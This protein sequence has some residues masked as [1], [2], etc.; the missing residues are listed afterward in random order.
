MT[1]NEV[2]QTGEDQDAEETNQ[3]LYRTTGADKTDFSRRDILRLGAAAAGAA[4]T[5]G[6][7]TQI[8][9]LDPV[10]EADAIAAS[11]AIAVAATGILV[12][13]AAENY[14]VFSRD[15]GSRPSPE[16]VE[17]A[18]ADQAH[19]DSY[20]NIRGQR[21]AAE[22]FHRQV[23]DIATGPKG[24]GLS[25]VLW[26][27]IRKAVY[28]SL[29]NGETVTEAITAA[30]DAARQY[31]SDRMERWIN[32]WNRYC[33]E[34]EYERYVLH[35]KALN[36]DTFTEIDVYAS[37]QYETY[38]YQG[39]FEAN[40]PSGYESGNI[41]NFADTRTKFEMTLPD[42]RTKTVEVAYLSI[43]DYVAGISENYAHRLY[44]PGATME[45]LPGKESTDW[46][47][48]FVDGHYAPLALGGND[49]TSRK[50]GGYTIS[51]S[52]V[53]SIASPYEDGA[54]VTMYNA[55][56][57]E[58]LFTAADQYHTDIQSQIG[59][60]VQGVYDA[61]NAGEINPEDILSGLDVVRGMGDS[62]LDRATAELIHAGFSV[63]TEDFSTRTT[64][65]GGG[66][67]EQKTGLL[68]MNLDL[69]VLRSW[70]YSVTNRTHDSN[71]D[72]TTLE[73]NIA[74]PSIDAN[75]DKD[76]D[77][78]QQLAWT[79]TVAPDGSSSPTARI[80]EDDLNDQQTATVTVSGDYSGDS[81]VNIVRDFSAMDMVTRV[82]EGQTVDAEDYDS[83]MLLVP[84]QDSVAKEHL[85]GSFTI[86]T[87]DVDGSDRSYLEFAQYAYRDG[88][89]SRSYE[90]MQREAEARERVHT[91]LDN[92][93]GGGG[94]GIN[95]GGGGGALKWALG[96]LGV[97]TVLGIIAQA[98]D[99]NDPP[100]RGRR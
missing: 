26:S 39:F 48:Q 99:D 100:R 32:E 15:K 95:I 55:Q 9:A 79:V 68:L 56:S 73:I 38:S 85:D 21:D 24:G 8:D 49:P 66:L 37:E 45:S 7:S 81:P 20:G 10:G 41:P 23:E 87:V 89:P 14:G 98:L 62:G 3:E 4:A 17:Q 29:V 1:S 83:A 18:V 93:A 82:D 12:Y 69:S 57:W 13:E 67:S 35:R 28:D 97:M 80:V 61:Y 16:E 11:S 54:E 94:G 76:T 27:E 96:G 91:T 72:E 19:I 30:R 65:S 36:D 46:P 6:A 60:Y 59:D 5:G 92:A 78:G 33:E 58:K 22:V 53:P 75:S 34:I 70:E 74:D 51:E 71:A 63:D 77:S 40:T 90:R 64:V 43:D 44:W 52:L 50:N 84:Q 42:G 88:V 25:A 31:I 86:E 2:D 47:Q